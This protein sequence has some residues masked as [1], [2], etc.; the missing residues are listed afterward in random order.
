MMTGDV[1]SKYNF[2][3]PFIF[4]SKFSTSLLPVYFSAYSVLRLKLPS[5]DPCFCHGK[6]HLS[7]FFFFIDSVPGV[8]RRLCQQPPFLRIFLF[9]H[10]NQNLLT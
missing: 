5:F 9:L 1:D 7:A 10:P 6:S 4:L 8:Q 2:H 3:L